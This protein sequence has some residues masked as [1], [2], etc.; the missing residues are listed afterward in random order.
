MAKKSKSKQVQHHNNQLAEDIDAELHSIRQL[1]NTII[2]KDNKSQ[3]IQKKRD[4]Q[5][6]YIKR[7][8]GRR[9]EKQLLETTLESTLALFSSM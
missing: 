2:Q 7:N 5:E 3:K 6:L 1:S 4:K 9:K 8:T